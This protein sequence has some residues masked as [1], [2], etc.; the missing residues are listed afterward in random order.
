M[1]AAYEFSNI[2]FVTFFAVL[3]LNT[4]HTAYLPIGGDVKQQSSERK[5]LTDE[6]MRELEHMTDPTYEQEE[7]DIM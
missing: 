2:Y 5:A 7:T 1:L 3:L 4:S 6:D